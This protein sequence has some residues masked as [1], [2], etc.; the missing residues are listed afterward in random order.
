MAIKGIII[1]YVPS[2]PTSVLG[3]LRGLIF[4]TDLNLPV[5]VVDRKGKGLAGCSV[6][7]QNP[8][9]GIPF[10]AFTDSN[11]NCLVNKDAANPNPV[12]VVKEKVFTSSN[13]TGGNSFTIVL[14]PPIFE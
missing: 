1:E 14:E 6:T 8:T 3:G 12:T 11:G 2:P 4:E 9:S 13:Y 5:K 10:T 7:I